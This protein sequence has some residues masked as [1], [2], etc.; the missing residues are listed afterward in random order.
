[1]NINFFPS[2]MKKPKNWFAAIE[3]QKNSNKIIIQ[4]CIWWNASWSSFYVSQNF[5]KV[6][7]LCR[8]RVDERIIWQQARHYLQEFYIEII[9]KMNRLKYTYMKLKQ[10]HKHIS[11]FSEF[12]SSIKESKRKTT[13]KMS[14][15]YVFN[16]EKNNLLFERQVTLNQTSNWNGTHY[17]RNT[18]TTVT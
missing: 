12:L 11:N 6:I 3:E 13:T 9:N 8:W 7:I 14:I 15:F 17:T 5:E 1:M 18:T 10:Q 16:L 4:M 2:A